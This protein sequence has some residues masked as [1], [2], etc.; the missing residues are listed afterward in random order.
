GLGGD[1]R[2]R[3]FD[4][5][6][7]LLA[8][9]SGLFHLSGESGSLAGQSSNATL[10][11]RGRQFQPELGFLRVD[12]G[13]LPRL[14]FV[15]RPDLS[16]ATLRLPYFWY[17]PSAGL[18]QTSIRAEVE[19]G[20]RADFSE[21]IERGLSLQGALE[22]RA[23]WNTY[24][25]GGWG[26]T[27]VANPFPL[28]ESIIPAGRYQGPRGEFGLRTPFAG[29][30]SRA[31]AA[32]LYDGAFFGGESHGVLGEFGLSPHPQVRL[33][34]AG[35]FSRLQLPREDWRDEQAWNGSVIITPTTKLQLD[36]VAQRNSQA[37]Q[38][39]GQARLRW[40]YLSG[41][42][43][44]LVYRAQALDESGLEE[45]RLMFKLIWR[46]DLLLR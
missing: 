44:F 31:A 11:W 6:L 16:N 20:W 30:R 22:T 3:F 9:H 37:E 33:G 29:A 21:E 12:E 36:L 28:G 8:A 45:Q 2:L 18:N 32:Y 17:K 25:K 40:R 27:L 10:R 39:I 34:L 23:G 13:Y 46:S 5:R 4:G 38:W 19:Q 35:L 43:L 15:R 41:S 14:G 24:L 42:D 7:D 26:E 1:G